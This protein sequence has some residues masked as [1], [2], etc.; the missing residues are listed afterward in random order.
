V[1]LNVNRRKSFRTVA[2]LGLSLLLPLPTRADDWP[3]WRGPNRDGV[4]NETGIMESFPSGGLKI[5]WRVPVGPGW[6][7]PVV[8]QGRVYVT[9]VELVRPTAKERVLCFEEATGKLLWSHRYA[10][11]YPEWAFDPNAGG[12]RATPIIRDGKL[13]T[14]GA[15]G[16]LF[17]LDAVTGQVVWEKNLAKEYEVKEFT[18]ITASPLIEDKLLILYIC[19]K[20]AACVVAFDKNSGKEAWRALDDSFTYSSPIIVTAGG[21]KQFIVWTQEAM[22]SLDPATGKIW[23]REQLRT[24]GDMAVSTP[25]YFDH[26]LLIGGLMLKLDADKPAA[27]VL[28]PETRVVS[29]RILSNTSTAL[30]RGEYVFSARTSGELVCLEAGTGKEIWQTNTVTSLKNGSS[31]HL[32]PN[33]DSVLLFTDQGNLIRAR[34]SS[35]GYQEL[36]RVHLL[37]ATHPF[38]GRNVVWPPPAYANHRVFARNDKEILCASLEQEP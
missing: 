23:W 21:K 2:A 22:T 36:S 13:F 28:W 38:N 35:E 34:L 24:S 16:H 31:I 37:D 11:D 10:V 29:K 9:D 7:S 20:P 17:C 1:V 27:S 8:A 32:T 15:L 6:S 12:P 14:L 33:G 30:L 5:S 19:G 26:R 4:W 25:V 3:Q 18:G